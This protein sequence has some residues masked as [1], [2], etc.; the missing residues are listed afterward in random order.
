MIGGPA[1]KMWFFQMVPKPYLSVLIDSN[2]CEYDILK[3]S[4]KK[5]DQNPPV[6]CVKHKNGYFWWEKFMDLAG[7]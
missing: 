4:L 3:V 2:R 1:Q 6:G 7:F 5:I